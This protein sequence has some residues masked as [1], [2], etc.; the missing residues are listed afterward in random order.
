MWQPCGA[1]NGV[2]SRVR[3]PVTVEAVLACGAPRRFVVE[4]VESW[5][6][7]VGSS[8]LVQIAM[9]IR[10]N[11]GVHEPFRAAADRFNL[12]HAGVKHC[13]MNAGGCKPDKFDGA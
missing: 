8:A 1:A 7:W 3:D 10:C 12:R 2:A 4:V 11:E 5:F 9:H 6:A 13:N